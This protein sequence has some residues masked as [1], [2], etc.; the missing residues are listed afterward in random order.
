MDAVRGAQLALGAT[1]DAL[2]SHGREIGMKGNLL[3]VVI[4]YVLIKRED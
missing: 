3:C 1:S 2:K 4:W